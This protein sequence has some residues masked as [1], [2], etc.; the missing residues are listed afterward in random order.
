LIAALKLTEP[1]IIV[2]NSELNTFEKIKDIFQRV[3]AVSF[4]T[5]NLIAASLSE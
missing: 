3:K 4:L 2:L 1:K 5:E